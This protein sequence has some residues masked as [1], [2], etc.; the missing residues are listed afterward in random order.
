MQWISDKVWDILRNFSMAHWNIYDEDTPFVLV[1]GTGKL[2]KS[3][4]KGWKNF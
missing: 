2:Q 4:M 1:K 3:W